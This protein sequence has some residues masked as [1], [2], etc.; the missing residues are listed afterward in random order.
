MKT[1]LA[2]AMEIIGHEGIVLTR[3]RDSKGIWTIG[4]GHTASAGK[5]IPASFTGKLTVKEAI[6]LFRRDLAKFEKRV[7]AAFKVKLRQHEFDAAVSFDFN[8]GAIDEATWVRLFNQGKRDEAVRAIMNWSKP[9]EIV[10]RRQKEQALFRSGLYRGGGFATLYPADSAGRVQWSKGRRIDLAK[11]YGRISE[12]P[13]PAPQSPVDA[14]KPVP[15]PSKGR[16]P[17]SPSARQGGWAAAVFAAIVAA[18]GAA[19]AIFRRK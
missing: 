13:I 2:G 14:R 15:A 7:N 10:P 8:T 1:S 11:E 6:D 12:E 17:Q 9:K 4:V 5:P 18:V 19:I 16:S 3:Y